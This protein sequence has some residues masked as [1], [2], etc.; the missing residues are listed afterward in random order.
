MGNRDSLGEFEQL[1]L[2]A[3]WKLDKKAY[4]TSIREAIE[5]ATERLIA[6]GALYTTLE[7]LQEKG[8]VESALGEATAERGGRAKRFFSITGSG[9]SILRKNLAAVRALS[10][11][12]LGVGDSL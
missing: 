1:V 10:A 5:E 4:G 9:A 12:F 3:V 6:I 7:R 11:G 2:L 8:F